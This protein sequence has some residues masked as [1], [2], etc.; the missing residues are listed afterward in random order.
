MRLGDA[1]MNIYLSGMIGSGKTTLGKALAKRLGWAFDDLDSA[2][3]AIAGKDFRQVVAE[4]GWLGFR[5]REYHICKQFAQMDQ[6]VIALGGG[7]VRYEWNR[8]VLKGTGVVVLLTAGLDVL[9]DRVRA[10]DRPRVNPGATIEEDLAQIWGNHQDLYFSFADVIYEN[11]QR[12]TVSEATDELL[13]ILQ[14]KYLS[15]R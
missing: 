3:E 5:Q 8:D 4:E 13:A 10:N 6:T 1:G 11:D 14:E 7:T 15:V 9:A 2:M 12:N